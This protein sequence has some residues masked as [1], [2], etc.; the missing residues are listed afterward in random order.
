[1]NKEEAI[2]K[3]NE[4]E[5]DDFEVFA[6]D[7]HKTYLENYVKTK[8][9][10]IASDVTRKIHGEYD[11]T[12]TELFGTDRNPNEKTY[13]FLKRKYGEFKEKAD[14]AEQYKSKIAELEEAVKNNTG[15]EQLKK[16]LESV[17]SEY[18][19]QQQEWSNKETEYSQKMNDYLL[20]NEL[21]K[22]MVGFKFKD[23]IPD[24]LVDT[25]IDKVK[26]ELKAKAKIVDGK[27]IFV[28]EE[29]KTLVNKDNALNPYTPQELLSNKLDSLLA[30]SKKIDGPPKPE[31][32]VVDGK[33]VT[34]LP[35]PNAQSR[36]E[37]SEYL[38]KN[39]IPNGSK[40]YMEMYKEWTKDMPALQ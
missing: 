35:N 6:A 31:T 32:K 15:D 39:G 26:T 22:A 4:Q 28:D 30:K 20:D 13:N 17:R 5:S 14:S 9:E 34:V 2:K 19:R 8:E 36:Q 12:L 3:I 29:G 33:E 1:M 40:E 23:D 24:E 38:K 21:D 16:E 10:E 7:E 25:Y 37:V 18:K 27:M 11:K